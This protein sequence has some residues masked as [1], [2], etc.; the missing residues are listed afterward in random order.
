M[1]DLIFS[2]FGVV[3]VLV[4]VLV[5]V[6]RLKAGDDAY[7]VPMFLYT[8]FGSVREGLTNFVSLLSQI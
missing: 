3:H 4:K 2:K 1:T 7:L 5:A 8:S 6:F